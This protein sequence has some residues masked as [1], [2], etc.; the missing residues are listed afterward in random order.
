ML[1]GI[2]FANGAFFRSLFSPL[3][4]NSFKLTHCPSDAKGMLCGMNLDPST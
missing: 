3:R 1:L 2:S 4:A